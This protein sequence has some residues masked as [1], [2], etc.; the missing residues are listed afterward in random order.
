MSDSPSPPPIQFDYEAIAAQKAQRKRAKREHRVKLMLFLIALAVFPLQNLVGNVRFI[1]N[2][3]ERNETVVQ[4][5]LSLILII[6]M[7]LLVLGLVSCVGVWWWQ[8][9]AVYGLALTTLG[10]LIAEIFLRTATVTDFIA[11]VVVIAALYFLIH[12]KWQYFE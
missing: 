8:R 1:V 7:T 9:W 3:A 4:V 12:K 10:N 11:P 5:D 2:L 6:D